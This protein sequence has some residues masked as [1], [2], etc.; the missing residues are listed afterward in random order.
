M[1]L[2][3]LF[4]YTQSLSDG[5]LDLLELLETDPSIFNLFVLSV[6]NEYAQQGL[7]T[8]LYEL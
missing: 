5:L 7:A 6:A 8:K 1:E 2:T 4:V 3:F